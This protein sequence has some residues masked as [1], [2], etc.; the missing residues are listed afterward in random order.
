MVSSRRR[1]ARHLTTLHLLRSR[2]HLFMTDP[3]SRTVHV[4]ARRTVMRWLLVTVRERSLRMRRI[5]V[6]VHSAPAHRR[7]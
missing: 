3:T 6:E 1:T 7:L 4:N 5:G 2:L